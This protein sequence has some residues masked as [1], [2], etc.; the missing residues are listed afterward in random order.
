MVWGIYMPD[1][2]V[3]HS[4]IHSK[5]IEPNPL[6]KDLI[7][8][9]KCL[10]P[11]SGFY[12]WDEGDDFAHPYY[13]YHPEMPLFTL[14]GMWTASIVNVQKVL[15]RFTILTDEASAEIHGITSQVPIIVP[16]VQ[17]KQWLED[18]DFEIKNLDNA[19]KLHYY[20]VSPHVNDPSRNDISLISPLV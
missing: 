13:F 2:K 3:P 11:I 17:H 1:D 6:L 10:V 5:K 8:K 9:N 19:P 4:H 18:P 14:A 20:K 15:Y 12:E 7:T 16:A